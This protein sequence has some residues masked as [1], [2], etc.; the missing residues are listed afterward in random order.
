MNIVPAEIV[1]TPDKSL[2]AFGPRDL[3]G[4][5]PP[6][7]VFNLTIRQRVRVVY[8]QIGNEAQPS[9]LSLMDTEGELSNCFSINQLVEQNII[10]KKQIEISP[11]CV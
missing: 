1:F 9:L 3:S 10:L 4:V 5:K 11:K 2:G 6:F 7:S 8:E